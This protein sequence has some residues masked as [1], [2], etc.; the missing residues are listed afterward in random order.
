MQRKLATCQS[1]NGRICFAS[2]RNSLG[3]FGNRKTSHSSDASLPAGVLRMELM[4]PHQECPAKAVAV[5]DSNNFTLFRSKQRSSVEFGGLAPRSQSRRWKRFREKKAARDGT[6]KDAT[7]AAQSK[8]LAP[9]PW[10][11]KSRR[12]FLPS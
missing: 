7:L 5:R 4:R 10:R 11:R 1:T 3:S 12:E 8:G 9:R 2:H 6:P